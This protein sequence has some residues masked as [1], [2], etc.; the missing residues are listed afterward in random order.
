MLF[1][2][3]ADFIIKLCALDLLDDFFLIYKITPA[4]SRITSLDLLRIKSKIAG[5]T[6]L[7]VGRQVYYSSIIDKIPHIEKSFFNLNHSEECRKLLQAITSLKGID[8][9]EGVLL[10]NLSETK[11]DLMYTGDHHCIRTILANLDKYKLF[12]KIQGRILLIEQVIVKIIREKTL[13]Q[14]RDKIFKG[15]SCD[16]ALRDRFYDRNMEDEELISKLEERILEF[17]DFLYQEE[18]E[19][20]Y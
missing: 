16:T 5:H 18:S 1:L 19:E 9:G 17:N 6:H 2:L 15:K 10:I 3:D 8:P 20:V 14:V 11:E 12:S 4:N 13:D 7:A